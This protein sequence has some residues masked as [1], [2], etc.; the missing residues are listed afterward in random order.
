MKKEIPNF[1]EI[2]DEKSLKSPRDNWKRQKGFNVVSLGDWLWLCRKIDVKTVPAIRVATTTVDLLLNFEKMAD[3]ENFKAFFD[4][5][6]YVKEPNTMLRWD[7]CSPLSVKMQLQD[8]NWA[9]S[10]DV[11]DGFTILDPRAYEMIYDYPGGIMDVWKRPWIKAEIRDDYPVEYRVFVHE[12]EVV[13]VT[14]YYIQRRLGLND[15]VH[16]EIS[17]CIS[18]AKRLIENI[19]PPLKFQGWYFQ[20]WKPDSKSASM[21]FIKTKE[22]EMIFLE[23]GPPFGANASPCCFPYASDF[24]NFTTE[25]RAIADTIID[26]VPIALSEKDQNTNV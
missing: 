19:D 10:Q 4:T 5:I 15:T 23:G 17:D 6:E 16:S 18:I 26:D 25:W 20:N 11:L 21:D 13:G 2:T 14:N 8:G 7:C 22:G 9:W 24:D 12:G 1:D 3:D